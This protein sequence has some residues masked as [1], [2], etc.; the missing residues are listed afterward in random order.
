M[1]WRIGELLAAQA[2]GTSV[3][4][5]KFSHTQR[6]IISNGN[7]NDDID[8]RDDDDEDEDGNNDD[9]GDDDDDDD[10]D[11]DEGDDDDDKGGGHH[12]FI[13]Y[14]ICEDGINMYIVTG[15]LP[16]ADRSS[17]LNFIAFDLI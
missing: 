17:Q 6:R 13:D 11:D 5:K 16:V 2:R 7:D 9:A 1:Q 14:N 3:V 15:I 4:R 12:C 8:D 10:D